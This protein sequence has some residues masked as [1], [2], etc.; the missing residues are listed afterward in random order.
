MASYNEFKNQ[1]L[2]KGFN[3]DGAYGNQCWDGYAKYCIY[4]GYPYAHCTTSGYVKD[5]YNNRKSNGILNYF[6]EVYT[7][8]AGDVCV[9]KEVKGVTPYSHIAIYDSDAGN[10]YGNF[11]G[12]NQGATNGNFNIVKLPYSATFY[13]AFRP[14]C[15]ASS[16]SNTTK[17]TTTSTK[18][19]QILQVGSR[20]TSGALSIG[21]IKKINGDECVYIKALGGYFP[22]KY[23]TE[24]DASDG[25]LDDYLANQKAKVYV[26]ECTVEAVNAKKNLV[27]IHGIWVD[28]TPLIEL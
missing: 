3:I 4:L 1:V 22:T 21:G 5:I 7:M 13:Y 14:K 25:K 20:V 27:K 17:T 11:L 15:F 19:D 8:K 18:A 12:Q 24:Y 10:G 28:P 6:D 2:G 26:Q 23:V 16:S 9:F